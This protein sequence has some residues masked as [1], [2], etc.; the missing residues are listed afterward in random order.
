M[1]FLGSRWSWNWNITSKVGLRYLFE[2]SLF[3]II[4]LK[5]LVAFKYIACMFCLG[6]LKHCFYEFVTFS[7][8]YGTRD[9]CSMTHALLLIV[10]TEVCVDLSTNRFSWRN[11]SGRGS[12]ETWVSRFILLVSFSFPLDYCMKSVQKNSISF[13]L[14]LTLD[15]QI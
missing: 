9:V 1:P 15:V 12:P 4:V 14:T 8:N 10:V 7:Y 6:L 13:G 5:G 11:W 3:P 2:T